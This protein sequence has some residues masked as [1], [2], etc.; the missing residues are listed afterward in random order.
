[1][2]GVFAVFITLSFLDFKE[3]GFG[4]AV[5]VLID[6]TIIRGIL[7]PAVDE[8]ARRLELVPAEL[9]RVA[10]ARRRG[11]RLHPADG[12]QGAGRARTRRHAAPGA[13]A[14]LIS[15]LTER[16]EVVVIGG[17][18]AGLAIGY[19]LARAERS[20]TILDAA[21]APAA[22]WRGRWDTLRLFTP[23]RYDSLPGRAFPGHPDAY[24]GRD[25]VV[26]YLTAYARELELP[27][28]LDT[29]TRAVRPRL[30]ILPVIKKVM[31]IS[32]PHLARQWTMRRS[33]S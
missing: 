9:A 1:M 26:D 28:E 29:T 4:L 15:G 19:L 10:A 11:T 21:D 23:V 32:P 14:G 8:A 30:R 24:P 7:L 18:Q 20:F 31:L 16:R 2:V 6:A 13:G 25:D 12:T 17:G 27:V 5:A 22:A 3:L 33:S